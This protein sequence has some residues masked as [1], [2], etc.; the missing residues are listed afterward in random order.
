MVISRRNS[1]QRFLWVV[2]SR[3]TASDVFL[4]GYAPTLDGHHFNK[5]NDLKER[6]RYK[7][8]SICHAG[9]RDL[10]RKLCLSRSVINHISIKDSVKDTYVDN[11][12]FMPTVLLK[13]GSGPSQ[14]CLRVSLL[15][16][17]SKQASSNRIRS[18]SATR[19]FSLWLG[20]NDSTRCSDRFPW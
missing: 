20:G 7:W 4:W 13:Q 17:F 16:L 1:V 15:S 2:F 14:E 19:H 9:T 12:S 5:T 8:Q 18:L 3:G 11:V 6:A 10:L